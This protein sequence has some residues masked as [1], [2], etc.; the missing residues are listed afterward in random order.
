MVFLVAA[1]VL[2]VVPGPNIIYIVTRGISQGRKTAVASALG[3]ET[4]I[5]V[6]I[7]A[8]AVGLSALVASSALAFNVVKYL[9]AAYLIYLALRAFLGESADPQTGDP[10]GQGEHRRAY[11]HGVVVSVLNVKVALF[12]LSFL[13]QFVDPSRGAATMQILVLGVLFFIVACCI[14]LLYAMTSG[15]IGGWLLRRPKVL[16]RQRYFSGTVY[17]ALG[18][19]AAVGGNGRQRG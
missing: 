19:A 3:V 12:F 13:P 5:L 14:D 17:L 1:F 6:H 18:I 4:G 2:I 9:G 11:V 10:E 16:Q 8:A 7:V 15:A